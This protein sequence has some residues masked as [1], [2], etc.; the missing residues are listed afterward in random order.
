MQLL[1]LWFFAV[2]ESVVEA[3]GGF[4]HEDHG[5]HEGMLLWVGAGKMLWGFYTKLAKGAKDA[6]LGRLDLGQ[7]SASVPLAGC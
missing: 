6:A 1:F 3:P 2:A 4:Y 5:G 7:C